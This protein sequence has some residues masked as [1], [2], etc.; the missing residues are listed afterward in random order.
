MGLCCGRHKSLDE[1]EEHAGGKFSDIPE[2]HPA[3]YIELAIPNVSVV[4]SEMSLGVEQITSWENV[5]NYDNIVTKFSQ[6]SQYITV[7]Q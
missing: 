2:L 1:K 7:T 3:V 5:V 4:S 6:V